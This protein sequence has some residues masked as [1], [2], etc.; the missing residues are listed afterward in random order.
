MY[1]TRQNSSGM[2]EARTVATLVGGGVML[3]T[4]RGIEGVFWEG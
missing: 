2:L 1:K 3:V 4:R